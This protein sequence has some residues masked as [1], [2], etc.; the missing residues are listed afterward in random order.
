MTI[1]PR[2][3]YIDRIRPYIGTS[4]IK[5]I[6]GQRRVGKSFVL[7]MVA[8]LLEEEHPDWLVLHLDLERLEWRHLAISEDLVREV[9][10]RT[11]AAA[12]DRGAHPARIALLLDEIQEVRGY[13]AAVRGFA[14]DGRFDVYISG[15]NADLLSGDIATLFAGRAVRIEVHPL[16]YDEFLRFHRLEDIDGSLNRY[17]RY[18]GLPFLSNLPS[19]DAVQIEY[20]GAVF[21]SVV[22]KDVVQRHGIR[23]PALLERIV[24][25]VADTVGSPTSARNI[26]NYLKSM[27]VEASPQ[28]VLDY[29]GYLTCSFAVVK[30]PAMDIA[31]KKILE[32]TAKYYFED[33]G[34]RGSIRGNR[35][36]DIGKIVENAVFNRLRADGWTL[37][38]GRAGAREIDFVGERGQ[39]RCY[40]QAAYLMPDAATR[41]R[42]FGV[43]AALEGGWPRYVVSMDPLIRNFEGIQ[44]LAL[45]DFLRD[46]LEPDKRL[47]QNKH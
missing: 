16:T 13:E 21:D 19:D 47:L 2:P 5:A 1:I 23:S 44:H 12:A 46:G 7:L 37:S 34:L 27:H 9:N 39:E 30:C 40:V 20:L 15:S 22:L 28:S 25:Y 24:E 33:L 14:A 41:E 11:A 18:G 36:A 8:Q 31:G 29:L 17:L 6:V 43:L 26:A 35:E 32:G 10:A 45:R 42:E 38:S 4:L 3:R